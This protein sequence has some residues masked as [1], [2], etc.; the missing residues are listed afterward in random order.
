[1]NTIN[2]RPGK[3]NRDAVPYQ[4]DILHALVDPDPEKKKSG[5]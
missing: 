5:L 4:R 3:R 2:C 1:V